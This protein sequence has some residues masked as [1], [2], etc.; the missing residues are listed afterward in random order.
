MSASSE[1][2][3]PLATAAKRSPFLHSAVKFGRNLREVPLE[4][5]GHPRRI[6]DVFRVLPETMLTMPRLFD[7]ADAVEVIDND[8]VVGDIVECGVWN[9]GCVGL[10]ALVDRRLPGPAR[11]I[12]LF[13]SFI[14]LPPPTPEDTD[15]FTDFAAS[16]EV[17]PEDPVATGAC[18][19]KTKDEVARFLT[20]RLGIDPD[21]LTFHEGWFQ[22]TIPL[23]T[24][25]I[26]EIALLRL[27]GDWYDSTRVCLEGLFDRITPGGYLI[28]DDYGT[29][30]GC[31]RAVD[32]FFAA[33]GETPE[34][35]Y[36]DS[37]CVYMRIPVPAKT[38]SASRPSA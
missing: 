34:W 26:R 24:E 1:V 19:G 20:G 2:L 30:E 10:M 38:T 11:T 33:R 25:V 13:D 6:V 22:D 3:R 18:A 12:H 29:F 7:I 16:S 35:T 5:W 32:E 8:H 28:V 23:A 17:T 21:S 4:R 15:V 37:S 9:G 36:S 31:R 14:G 27:D